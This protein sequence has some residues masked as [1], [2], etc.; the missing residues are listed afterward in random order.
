MLDKNQLTNSTKRGQL[1][2]AKGLPRIAQA[3][4]EAGLTNF[5]DH[6]LATIGLANILLDTYADASSSST[7]LVS[8]PS[9][10]LAPIPNPAVNSNPGHFSQK[11]STL[12]QLP[13][14]NSPLGL[15]IAKPAST[16]SQ[17]SK[18]TQLLSNTASST[19]LLDRLAARDRAHG[20]LSA[21]TKSGQGWNNSEAWF[22]LAR[23]YE[24]GG[25]I[26]KSRECLWWCIELEEARAI[27]GWDCVAAGGYVL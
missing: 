22:A 20:L 15:S 9:D 27:R 4:Y 11:P 7:V 14:N 8:N 1:S 12:P 2:L 16:P 24:E 10:P 21:L 18:T 23:A 19:V 6:P 3:D 25:Q 5:A 17:F 13:L 26:D